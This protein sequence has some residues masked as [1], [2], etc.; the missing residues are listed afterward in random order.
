[1]YLRKASIAFTNVNIRPSSHREKVQRIR[2]P[3]FVDLGLVWVISSDSSYSFYSLV[4][5]GSNDWMMW[6]FQKLQWRLFSKILKNIHNNIEVTIRD[7]YG[8]DFG[9]LHQRSYNV[10][11]MYSI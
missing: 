6:L 11:I 4:L 8:L 10:E 1:M 9:G 2:G 5:Y 3:D 7:S